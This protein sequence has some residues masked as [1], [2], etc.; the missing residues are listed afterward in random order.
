MG[1]SKSLQG[2]AEVDD[3]LQLNRRGRNA[4]R[5]N[6]SEVQNLIREMA[7]KE[8]PG[9][10][11]DSR[12]GECTYTDIGTDEGRSQAIKC[13]HKFV[14]GWY[15][16]TYGSH[17][18]Y[19]NIKG[20]FHRSTFAPLTVDV[21][22]R[23]AE[24]DDEFIQLINCPD[25]KDMTKKLAKEMKRWSGTTKK[26][27][28]FDTNA[29][30]K[31]CVPAEIIT[32]TKL[33]LNGD[34][35]VWYTLW[36]RT[37]TSNELH[38]FSPEPENAVQLV[39]TTEAI[40][41]VVLTDDGSWRDLGIEFTAGVSER[42][43]DTST[44]FRVHASFNEPNL[45]CYYFYEINKD[46]VVTAD[47]ELDDVRVDVNLAELGHEFPEGMDVFM[48]AVQQ[49]IVYFHRFILDMWRR[50]HNLK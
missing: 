7:R 26:Y 23:A 15:D 22:Q 40:E 32:N 44:V 5:T 43:T 38:R 12:L 46:G 35:G 2:G 4:G 47:G 25:T 36:N 14:E 29:L 31:P 3:F 8:T 21:F 34:T 28:N 6:M 24:K 37:G 19:N 9:D 11:A 45:K 48:A 16:R 1:N 18:T 30:T 50:H 39:N 17:I 10:H 41:G 42:T 27:L 49:N 13:L 33:T 20:Y